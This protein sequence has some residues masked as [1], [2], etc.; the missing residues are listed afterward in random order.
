MGCFYDYATK[1]FPPIDSVRPEQFGAI[2]EEIHN[3]IICTTVA[4]GFTV[5]NFNVTE[6]IITWNK[7]CVIMFP[8]FFTLNIVASL[9]ILVFSSSL[10]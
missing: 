5:I 7:L 3:V 9:Y 1:M 6:P 4:T 2:F 8:V 10:F